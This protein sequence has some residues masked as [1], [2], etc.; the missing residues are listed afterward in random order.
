MNEHWTTGLCTTL[1]LSKIPGTGS[2]WLTVNQACSYLTAAE[3]GFKLNYWVLHSGVELMPVMSFFYFMP[4]T[5]VPHNI[6]Y[7]LTE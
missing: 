1:T 7:L 6:V 4:H 2:H 5:F 3:C